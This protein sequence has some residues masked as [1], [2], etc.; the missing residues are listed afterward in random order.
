MIAPGMAAVWLPGIARTYA[1]VPDR[2][3]CH[4][5]HRHIDEAWAGV[6]R[7]LAART[8][9]RDAVLAAIATG[10]VGLGATVVLGGI[11]AFAEYVRIVRETIAVASPLSIP[12]VA[13]SVGSPADWQR[14][15]FVAVLLAAAGSIVLLRRYSSVT[16]AIAVVAAVMA[17]TVVR[18]DTLVVG[19]AA[20]T[21]WAAMRAVGPAAP[22]VATASDPAWSPSRMRLIGGTAVLIGVLGVVLA[23]GTGGLDRSSLAITNDSGE[24]LVVRFTVASQ[25]ASFGYPVANG[26]TG[27]AWGERMGTVTQTILVFAADCRLLQRFEPPVGLQGIRITGATTEPVPSVAAPYLRYVPDCATEARAER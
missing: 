26:E 17:T 5:G 25:D 2:G 1:A 14:P 16:F 11:D 19:L 15:A 18:F 10:I 20:L 24:A 22:D 23:V 3:R 6:P 13:A 21:P 12:G 27:T 7:S 9:R 4:R 8:G